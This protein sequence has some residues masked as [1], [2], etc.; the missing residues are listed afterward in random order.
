MLLIGEDNSSERKL[1]E[2]INS[3]EE[4]NASLKEINILHEKY[5]EVLKKTIKTLTDKKELMK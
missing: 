4:S 2:Y 1:R 5:E 3:L